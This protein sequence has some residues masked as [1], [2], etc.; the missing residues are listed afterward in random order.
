M[1]H[2]TNLVAKIPRIARW[3][4]RR[5]RIGSRCAFSMMAGRCSVCGIRVEGWKP[6]DFYACDEHL[7]QVRE[8]WIT[9]V[10]YA[11]AKQDSDLVAR[12]K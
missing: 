1:T 11:A 6:G 10:G 12:R 2:T 4:Q 5:G 8:R 7:E 3:L 9:A